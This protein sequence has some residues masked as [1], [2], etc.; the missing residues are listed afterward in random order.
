MHGIIRR[1]LPA[2]LFTL[3]AQPALAGDLAAFR[4][5]ARAASQAFMKKLAGEMKA[6]LQTGGPAQALQVCKDRAPA[7]TSAESRRRG[8]KMTRVSLKYRDPML[9]MPDAWEAARLREFARRRARGEDIAKLEVVAEVTDPTGR[10]YYRYLKAIGTRPVCLMC[11]GEPDQIAPEVR[12]QLGKLYPHDL[13]TGFHVGDI[14]GA[15]SIK[16]P[17]D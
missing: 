12:R 14:R 2:L 15:I 9:G 7:I 11:H 10:R 16:A 4:Q 8:W 1:S 6:A 5:Q 13:A 3:A 17:A